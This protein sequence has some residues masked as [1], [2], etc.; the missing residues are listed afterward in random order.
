MKVKNIYYN[1][2][3][4]YGG[5]CSMTVAMPYCSFKCGKGLCQN[6][7]LAK[8]PT[9]EIT[10]EELINNF[11]SSEIMDAVVFQGLEPFD[12]WEDIQCFVEAY[13]AYERK[14]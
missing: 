1:D 9:I 7:S 11:L 3:I 14:Q 6:S 5:H 10:C 13:R 8:S 2:F 12:S 4:N